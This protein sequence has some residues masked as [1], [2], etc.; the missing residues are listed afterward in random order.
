[1][2]WFK[3]T[4]SWGDMNEDVRLEPHIDSLLEGR[5]P[6]IALWAR[7]LAGNAA[8]NYAAKDPLVAALICDGAYSDIPSILGLP[9]WLAS[10]FSGLKK[11]AEDIADHAACSK[12]LSAP[13]TSISSSVSGSAANKQSK[14]SSN[15]NSNSNSNS[16]NGASGS[17]SKGLNLEPPW[18]IVSKLWM[19]AF[20]LHGELD[21]RVPSSCARALRSSHAGESQMLIVKRGTHDSERPQHVLAQMAIFL[22]RAMLRDDKTDQMLSPH[23]ER[24]RRAS[25][26]TDDSELEAAGLQLWKHPEDQTLDLPPGTGFQS[27]S[28]TSSV[29]A[30]MLR[31]SLLFAALAV[32]S[33]FCDYDFKPAANEGS[34]RCSSTTASSSSAV[35]SPQFGGGAGKGRQQH[36]LHVLS[37]TFAVTLPHSYSEITIALCQ[38]TKRALATGRVA[39]SVRFVTL[40]GKGLLTVSTT[41]M[42]SGGGKTNN[43]NNMRNDN[44][45]EGGLNAEHRKL[46]KKQLASVCDPRARSLRVTLDYTNSAVIVH[47]DHELVL[48]L[49]LTDM[50]ECAPE[51]TMFFS[52]TRGALCIGSPAGDLT[53]N[54]NCNCGSPVVKK[55][56]EEPCTSDPNDKTEG[57]KFFIDL[58]RAHVSSLALSEGEDDDEDNLEVDDRGARGPVSTKAVSFQ[59]R[60]AQSAASFSS[61]RSA[62]L[63]M[64]SPFAQLPSDVPMPSTSASAS[65]NDR[66]SSMAMARARLAQAAAGFDEMPNVVGEHEHSWQRGQPRTQKFVA[67]ASPGAF[68]SVGSSLA[69]SSGTAASSAYSGATQLS[70]GSDSSFDF[71]RSGQSK[72]HR[73]Q[74]D[75]SADSGNETNNNSK[76]EGRSSL[77]SRQLQGASEHPQPTG[78]TTLG[79]TPTVRFAES[80]EQSGKFPESRGE[81]EG[82]GV[83]EPDCESLTRPSDSIEGSMNVRTLREGGGATVNWDLAAAVPEHA[84]WG[85]Q[86]LMSQEQATL[87]PPNHRKSSSWQHGDAGQYL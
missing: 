13:A 64:G 20:Y 12:V 44:N 71:D 61:V 62:D 23:L 79:A 43:N 22:H 14:K 3:R 68:S 5:S 77:D 78:K 17:K 42:V 19:P 47:L 28:A 54:C 67:G 10:P 25:L 45:H 1:M 30:T 81:G 40:S 38:T 49:P 16:S 72:L 60:T 32:S 21:R 8:L 83:R 7:G 46:V 48:D 82:P 18:E 55:G 80:L 75:S 39:G 53:Y 34:S 73:M 63:S 24:L 70:F 41:R 58:R 33:A 66:F 50:A 85:P 56:R 6:C 84:T 26:C 36:D 59:Q 35:L 74:S 76:L 52:A 87:A 11:I 37:N 86:G 31:R 51:A 4:E 69:L 27:W 15:S 57:R 2:F 29:D 65:A 9:S